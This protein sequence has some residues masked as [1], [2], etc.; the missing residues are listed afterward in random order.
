MGKVGPS[1]AHC[2]LLA[3]A[4]VSSVYLLKLVISRQPHRQSSTDLWASCRG[5]IWGFQ[6]SATD[7]VHLILYTVEK[8]LNDENLNMQSFI[9]YIILSN[10]I[11]NQLIKVNSTNISLY[12]QTDELRDKCKINELYN[13]ST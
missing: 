3:L 13:K 10:S 9:R 11:R 6:V 5:R 1:H 8:S 12:S 7:F 2:A 4:L